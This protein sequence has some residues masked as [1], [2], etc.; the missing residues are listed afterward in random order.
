MTKNVYIIHR[1]DG[2][3][4][5]DWYPWLKAELEAKDLQ[6]TIPAMPN[7]ETPT[8]EEWIPK[9]DELVNKPNENTLLI[10]HSVGCQTIIR[11]LEKLPESSQVGQVILVAPW[12][13]LVNLE[14]PDEEAVAAPWTNTPIDWNKAKSKCDNFVSFFSSDDPWVPV[15]EMDTFKD[16][17]DSKT[18][19]LENHGHFTDDTLPEIVNAINL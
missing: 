18:V 13:N 10:G 5:D 9:L 16:N 19:L 3:P 11:Y 2:A 12:I 7:T 17:L 1:W 8:I 6:V 15:S 4:D 14:G